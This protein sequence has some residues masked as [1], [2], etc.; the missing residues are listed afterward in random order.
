MNTFGSFQM[1]TINGLNIEI[2]KLFYFV[3]NSYET[4]KI[5]RLLYMKI[6]NS[7]EDQKIYLP[8]LYVIK[9]TGNIFE[10][11]SRVATSNNWIHQEE[12]FPDRSKK[13]SRT[14][15]FTVDL[16]LANTFDSLPRI[17]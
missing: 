8:L 13:R 3:L 6:I 12:R 5:I 17:H 1:K 7:Q 9:C 16:D 15:L 11:T 10:K 14:D 4:F 2:A